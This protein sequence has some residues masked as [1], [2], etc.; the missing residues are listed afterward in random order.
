MEKIYG[1][2]DEDNLYG[3]YTYKK[4]DTE[5]NILTEDGTVSSIEYRKTDA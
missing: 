5:L 3:S 1:E 4:G 2:P